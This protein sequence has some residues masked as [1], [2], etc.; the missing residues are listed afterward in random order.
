MPVPFV[1]QRM[2]HSPDYAL[3]QFLFGKEYA[4]EQLPFPQTV[5][6]AHISHGWITI[7]QGIERIN[8]L[9]LIFPLRMWRCNRCGNQ[10]QQAFAS[11][12]HGGQHVVYCRH[13]LH[14]GA[15][16]FADSRLV[17]WSGPRL[18]PEWMHQ[19]DEALCCWT[20]TLTPVQAAAADKMRATLG[21]G[22]SFLL[23]SVTGS[24]KTEVMYPAI[25]QALR[26]GKRVAVATPRAD[27]VKELAPRLHAA[28]PAVRLLT[29]YGGS[30]DKPAPSPLV[31]ATTHQL[32]HFFH[33]FDQIII[34]EVDAFPYSYDPM[35]AFAVRKAAVP[36]APFGYLTATPPDQLRRAFGSGTLEGVR[37]AA[38]F[39]AHPLPLPDF[40][41]IGN[42]RA[43]LRT[44]RLPEVFLKWMNAKCARRI[45]LFVFVPTVGAVLQLTESLQRQGCGRVVGVH[46]HDPHRHRKVA[47]FRRRQLD[48]LV[49][50]TILERGV[51]IAGVE[52]AVFGA[53]DPIFDERALVQIAGRVGRSVERP[54]GDVLFFHNGSTR[55]MHRARR[56]IHRMNEEAKL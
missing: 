39:H 31:V 24:G 18:L 1:T 37:I 38:R 15:P 40:H 41:W 2:E 51:T 54:E 27:V 19:P 8:R 3:Q 21:Q 29:L 35:L 43:A 33:C 46:A 13:C 22:R 25:E 14:F 5:I 28:F 53:D 55:A 34:D 26:S 49:T 47:D 42:W 9:P 10:N 17:T 16:V 36:G 44:G 52:V 45:P 56:H 11:L 50:T 32:L 6:S 48:V 7:R 30:T 20:G 23:W 12:I 4:L